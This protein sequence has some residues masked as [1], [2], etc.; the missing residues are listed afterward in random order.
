MGGGLHK[1][2]AQKTI[3][4]AGHLHD[5]KL[6][7]GRCDQL[8]AKEEAGEITHLTQQPVFQIRINDVVVCKV[9]GDF[10]YR[11]ADSGLL[12][13]EDAKGMDNAMSRLKRKMVEAA[14]PGTVMTI[15]PP[16]K[17]KV[18]KKAK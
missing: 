2:R 14:Y 6:E 10:Q 4:D 3:C 17:R 9:L 7:A 8:T 15:W 13:T 11:M 5:S 16:K 1:F 12:I 18:R